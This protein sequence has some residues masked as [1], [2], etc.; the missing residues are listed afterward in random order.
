M[1]SSGTF[2][3]VLI[4]VAVGAAIG[5]VFAPDNGASTRKKAKKAVNKYAK[6]AKEELEA[7]QKAITEQTNA[8]VSA[9][10]EKTNE[11][12]N[13]TKGKVNEV[14]NYKT[15]DAQQAEPKA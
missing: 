4:A 1:K 14:A 7:S 3:S 5:V 9:V 10:K 6:K 8:A 11:A 15:S 13:Y 12:A 2:L